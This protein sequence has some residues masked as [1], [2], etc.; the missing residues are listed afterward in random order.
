MTPASVTASKSHNDTAVLDAP[1]EAVFGY[2]AQIE[3]LPDAKSGG[4]DRVRGA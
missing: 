1:K 2:L 4:R 3:N